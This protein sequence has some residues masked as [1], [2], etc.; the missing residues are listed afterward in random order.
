M[1]STVTRLAYGRIATGRLIVTYAVGIV[2]GAALA[3]ALLSAI[4]P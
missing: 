3:I 1:S 4:S 2:V